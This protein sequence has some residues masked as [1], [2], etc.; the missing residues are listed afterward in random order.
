MNKIT[1]TLKEFN[2][3]RNEMESWNELDQI[4]NSRKYGGLVDFEISDFYLS[5]AEDMIDHLQRN[6]FLE[7]IG[8]HAEALIG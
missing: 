5:A 8:D 6:N 1:L 7:N 4:H 2:Q 3:L